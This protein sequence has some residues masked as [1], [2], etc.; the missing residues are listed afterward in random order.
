MGAVDRRLAGLA[1]EGGALVAQE[2][3]E[4]GV[5]PAFDDGLAHRLGHELALGDGLQVLLA[6]AAGQGDEILLAQARGLAQHRLGHGDGVAAE[7]GQQA[8]QVGRGGGQTAGQ[9]DPHGLF[10]FTGDTLHHLVEQ[11]GLGG[12]QSLGWLGQEQVGDLA[13]QLAAALA[14]RLASQLD[15]GVELGGSHG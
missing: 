12:A 10:H 5:I 7:V 2:H 11:G 1:R 6:S 9:L 8:G 4:G 13:Q 15:Q 3:T 14:G